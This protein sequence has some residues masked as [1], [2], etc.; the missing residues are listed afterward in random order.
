VHL[1]TVV[2]VVALSAVA[3]GAWLSR[4]P[5][6]VRAAEQRCARITPSCLVLAA[7]AAGSANEV[8]KPANERTTV[9]AWQPSHQADTGSDWQEYVVCG[10]IVDRAIALLPE[11]KHVKGWETAMGLSGSNSYRPEP[12]NA[13]AFDSEIKQANVANAT[14]FVSVH[15][16]GG[17]PSGIL[18]MCMPGDEASRSMA[19]RFKTALC[20]ATG[21]PDRGMREERLYSLDPV[22][23]NADLRML[24]EIG[25]NK[26]D[27][28]FLLDAN[29]RQVI[30]RAL[31][32]AV[33]ESELP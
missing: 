16:D 8:E 7:Y 22:R 28:A 26:A 27:R 33:R 23:N 31:A 17:A 15:N 10:D 20:A 5:A 24:L 9:I 19:E 29:N 4:P 6:T 18:G 21:L 32:D 14:V 2:L 1:P 11:F 30:A 25:D 12:K 13:P 3:S